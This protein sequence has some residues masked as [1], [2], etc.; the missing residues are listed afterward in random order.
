MCGIGGTVDLSNLKSPEASR[1][2]MTAMLRCMSHRGP[3]AVGQLD[4]ESAVL[5]ATR[6]AIRGLKDKCNQPMVDV[7]SG[8][9]AVCNGACFAPS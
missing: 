1:L 4:T 2:R 7:E 6:L 5:G 8:V 3:D 9:I